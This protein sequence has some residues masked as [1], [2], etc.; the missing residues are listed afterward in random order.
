M[1]WQYPGDA[2]FVANI[3]KQLTITAGVD[4]DALGGV[5]TLESVSSQSKVHLHI[6]FGVDATGFL[7]MAAP[8]PSR[9]W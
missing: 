9:S 3:T 1:R 7:S 2:I 6:R 5:I 8:S 4:I